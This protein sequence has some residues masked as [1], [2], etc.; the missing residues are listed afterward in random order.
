MSLFRDELRKELALSERNNFGIE[1]YDEL[2]FGK[3]PYREE[4]IWVKIKR[5]IKDLTGYH[6][7]LEKKQFSSWVETVWRDFSSYEEDL[8]NLYDRVDSTGKRLIVKLIAYRMLGFRKIKLPTNDEFYWNSIEIARTLRVSGETYEPHFL[9]F[10]L[11]KYDLKKLGSGHDVVL[12]F[13]DGGIAVDFLI[14][15]YCY[16]SENRENVF[17]AKGDT[18]LDLGGCWG[19]TALYFA[20][21]V[22]PQGK[23]YSFEFVPGN[24]Q[25]FN[26][27]R[28]LNPHLENRIELVPH[29][30]SDKTGEVI[31]YKDNGPGTQIATQPFEGQT[32]LTTTVSIDD[33]V[34]RNGISK[35]DFIKM[36]IEGTE[37][38]ALMGGE[39]TIRRFKPKLAISIYHSL[40]DFVAIPKWIL[41]LELGYELFLTHNTIHI[42]ETVCFAQIRK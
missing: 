24:I 13:N 23:V 33:F 26:L 28:S 25:I 31:Y 6:R 38:K 9:H 10:V 12:F 42:E 17:A 30:V 41:D 27:N 36:D 15:Q 21:K 29:P 35:I 11:N 5:M 22:G 20:S 32:G 40:D 2:R 16:K 19:D 4:G 1:N 8:S 7:S 14:E 37:L 34:I 3:Y 18:V 39:E